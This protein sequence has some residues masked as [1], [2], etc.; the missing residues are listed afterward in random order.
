MRLRLTSVVIAVMA[1]S[2]AWATP[3]RA[4][5]STRLVVS[6]AWFAD[7]TAERQVR[8]A[9]PRRTAVPYRTSST[10]AAD[11]QVTESTPLPHALYQRPPPRL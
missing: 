1:L 11:S 2:G 9:V 3:V 7:D 10:P 8:P 6:I 5:E 4:V